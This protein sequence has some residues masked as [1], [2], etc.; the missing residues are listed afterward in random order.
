MPRRLRLYSL[1]VCQMFVLTPSSL[2]Y[3]NLLSHCDFLEHISA[4]S[5]KCF[6]V[7]IGILINLSSSQIYRNAV[8]NIL[9]E[10]NRRL[11]LCHLRIFSYSSKLV[12]PFL[13][14]SHSH[15]PC[16]LRCFRGLRY[17]YSSWHKVCLP[18]DV[19]SFEEHDPR[20]TA[21]SGIVHA[22]SRSV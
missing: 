21:M 9:F 12:S 16:L 2:R 22:G 6:R 1:R 17:S 11:E 7:G 13:S 20:T 18:E 10:F 8:T 4:L 5:M 15:T 19:I 14:L 3:L